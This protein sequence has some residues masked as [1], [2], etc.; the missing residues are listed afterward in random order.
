L[1]II[2]PRSSSQ[3]EVTN[4]GMQQSKQCANQ[5][6]SAKSLGASTQGYKF[7]I[8]D[9]HTKVEPIERGRDGRGSSEFDMMLELGSIHAGQ[10]VYILANQSNPDFKQKKT[11]K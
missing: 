3:G 2:H 7:G 6:E 1:E 11:Y 9:T 10:R 5:Y 4:W 8:I